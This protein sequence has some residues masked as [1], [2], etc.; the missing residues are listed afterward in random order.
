MVFNDWERFERSVEVAVALHRNSR[1]VTGNSGHRSRGP[2]N[3]RGMT[4]WRRRAVRQSPEFPKGSGSGSGDGDGDG[5]GSGTRER[6][7]DGGWET[8]AGGAGNSGAGRTGW[9]Q[10]E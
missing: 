2:F 3:S 4:G 5:G 10:R 1:L 8:V 7:R 9:A 6:L